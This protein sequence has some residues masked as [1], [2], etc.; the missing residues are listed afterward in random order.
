MERLGEGLLDT[1]AGVDI[2]AP[3]LEL[4][5]LA[6]ALDVLSGELAEAVN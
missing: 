2:D 4:S 6:K 1:H 5:E 3:D